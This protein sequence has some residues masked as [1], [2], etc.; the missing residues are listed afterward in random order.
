[1]LKPSIPSV[2]NAEQESPDL[3]ARAQAGDADAFCRLCENHEA[4]L[5]RHAVSL[6][7][8]LS[9]A[10]ELAQDTLVEA[11]KSLHRYNGRCQIFTW[12]C[13]ILLNRYRN[14]CRKRRPM[15]FSALD[16]AERERA[17]NTLECWADSACRPDQSASE[18]ERIQLLRLGIEKLPAKHREVVFLR[19]FVDD[20]VESIAAALNCSIGTVKS[21]LFY[22]LDNLREMR[23]VIEAAGNRSQKTSS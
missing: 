15:P 14:V 8:E 21:R 23:E 12:F 10:E 16:S 4:R 22:A 18:Q 2:E 3:L 17:A 6:C 5:F 11:W 19:F 9:L 7:G 20:S 1:M 13:A